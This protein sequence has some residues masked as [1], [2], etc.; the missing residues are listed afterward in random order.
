MKK[1]LLILAALLPLM[2]LPA[3]AQDTKGGTLSVSGTGSINKAPDMA[4]V[5]A[6]VQS[7]AET[8]QAALTDN[9]TKMQSLFDTLEA[10]GIE[11]KDIQTSNFNIHPQLVYPRVK[12]NEEEQAPK[13]VGY[14]VNNQVSVNIYK[15]DLVG[16]VLTALVD[17]GANN[18]SGL[19]FDISDKDA[20]LD[21]ARK[22][23]I[24][25]ARAKAELYAKELGTSIKRLESLSESGGFQ[26]P[27]PVMMR[28]KME[29]A[30]A[31]V[32]V[33]EGEMSISITVNTSWEL[34][35]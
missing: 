24:A 25:D 13:I 33:A 23:A 3:A 28:A 2:A 5:S 22:Q 19:S 27:Q 16:S 9:N 34:D 7:R 4:S 15:L 14:V 29:L 1:R 10:A 31:P 32:P 6:G 18:I 11:K 20:L 17:A 26:A 8:A 35:N 12:D 21:E 30:A